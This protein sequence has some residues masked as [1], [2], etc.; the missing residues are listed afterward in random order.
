MRRPTT[1]ARKHKRSKGR[2]LM[3]SYAG[4]MNSKVG[5]GGERG[6]PGPIKELHVQWFNQYIRNTMVE[7]MCD[8]YRQWQEAC[9]F[10]WFLG[11]C[12][13]CDFLR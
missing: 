1:F 10:T 2:G 5:E 13:P 11:G 8:K 4:N 3:T 6:G 12:V 7:E 9:L